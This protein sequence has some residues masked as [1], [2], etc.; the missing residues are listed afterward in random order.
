[1]IL[2]NRRATVD[3]I[4]PHRLRLLVLQPLHYQKLNRCSGLSIVYPSQLS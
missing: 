1:M 3:R 2:E 4:K